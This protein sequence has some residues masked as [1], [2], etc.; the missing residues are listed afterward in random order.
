MGFL[1][2]G[3]HVTACPCIMS[4]MASEARRAMRV[5][6]V[7]VFLCAVVWAQAASL[8]SEYQHHHS[9]QHCCALCHV[10][11]LPLLQP[12]VAAAMAPV[13]STVWLAWSASAG[14]PREVLLSA[15]SSRA[16]PA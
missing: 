14:T 2:H 5:S 4:K 7:L 3:S 8:A 6:L 13:V 15:G 1:G 12:A 11:P 10:G 9:S 16:P